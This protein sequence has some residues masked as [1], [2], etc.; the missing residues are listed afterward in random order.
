MKGKELIGHF[1]I[2]S[3]ALGREGSLDKLGRVSEK[4]MQITT[5]AIYAVTAWN[6]LQITLQIFK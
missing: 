6:L 1:F 3:Y 4:V 5:P 2:S